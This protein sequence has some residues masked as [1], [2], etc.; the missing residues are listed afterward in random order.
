MAMKNG[1]AQFD[2]LWPLGRR[3]VRAQKLAPRL[4]DLRGKTV[5][6]LWDYRRRGEIVYPMIRE[7]L[8]AHYPGIKF[9]EYSVFG[10][11]H[12][13]QQK[14]IIADLAAKIRSNGCDA[15]VSGIGA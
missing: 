12:G 6:E 7:H 1:E 13:G 8:R 15:I 11:F 3:A 4:P 14:G 9:V 5:G 10:N 2:V